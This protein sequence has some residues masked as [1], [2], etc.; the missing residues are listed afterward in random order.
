MRLDSC[1]F[2]KSTTLTAV[3]LYCPNMRGNVFSF[4]YFTHFCIK[5]FSLFLELSLRNCTSIEFEFI[6]GLCFPKMERLDFYRTNVTVKALE[7]CL[8]H[9]RQLKHINLGLQ[10]IL[11]LS[12]FFIVPVN[13]VS[14]IILLTVRVL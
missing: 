2:V 1:G 12:L 11:L 13:L 3:S 4:I 10:Y 6:C 9:M 7:S 8:Y 5:I 14:F